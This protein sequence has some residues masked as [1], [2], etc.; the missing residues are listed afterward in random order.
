MSV[1]ILK[2]LS[3][4]TPLIQLLQLPNSMDF[5]KPVVGGQVYA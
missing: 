4:T 1:W 5:R 3:T 2:G